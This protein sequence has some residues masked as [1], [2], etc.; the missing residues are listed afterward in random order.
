VSRKPLIFVLMVVVAALGAWAVGARRAA[1][2]GTLPAVQPTGPIRVMTSNIRFSDPGD[3]VNAW[4]NRRELLVK[5]LLKHDP[6]IIGC[7]EVTP[8][9]GAFLVK[10]LANWYTHYP[11][12]G[13]GKV[14]GATTGGLSG[15]LMGALS[16]SAAGLN[17]LFYRTARFEQLDG[18]AGLVLPDAPQANP[19]EN[20]FYTL[21]VLRD[22]STGAG[23]LPELVVIDTHLRHNGDFAVKCAQ[24]LHEIAARV[25]GKY[26]G[27]AVILMGDINHDR[28]VSVHDA[29]LGGAKAG[30][31][32]QWMDAF[33]YGAH[34]VRD[35]WGTFHNFTGRSDRAWPTDLI[36]VSGELRVSPAEIVRDGER[37]RYPSDHFPVMAE[38]RAAGVGGTGK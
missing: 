6:D 34:G 12:P 38:V 7:Q 20:T 25:Q 17:T 35:L 22:K 2:P 11:R 29:L 28:T 26:P 1:G 36:F 9:Q 5:T 15:E 10:E 18:E 13:V 3:G 31:V 16:I 33:D 24:R 30:A 14:Q 32:G 37:G 27:S 23:K 21:A 4:S 19:S 8:A